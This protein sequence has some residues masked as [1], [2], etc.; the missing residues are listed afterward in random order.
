MN[1]YHLSKI[2]SHIPPELDLMCWRGGR[3]ELGVYA[4]IAF[5]REGARFNAALI[6]LTKIGEA[7]KEKGYHI[8]LVNR[9]LR[10]WIQEGNQRNENRS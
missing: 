10:V 5:R 3:V 4:C 2:A 7:L 6:E 9:Y 8:Q 1:E